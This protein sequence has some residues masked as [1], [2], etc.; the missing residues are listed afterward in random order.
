MGYHMPFL[1]HFLL[2]NR[3]R[4]VHIRR[5]HC[6]LNL[7]NHAQESYPMYVSRPSFVWEEGVAVQ[8]FWLAVQGFLPG[9]VVKEACRGLHK[10]CTACSEL[11]MQNT[12]QLDAV[13]CTYIIIIYIMLALPAV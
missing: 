8:L 9:E 6:T 12:E 5:F 2:P 7:A 13:V 1:M 3:V 10:R 4:H 11:L